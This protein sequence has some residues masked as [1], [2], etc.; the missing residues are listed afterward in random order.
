MDVDV[1]SIRKKVIRTKISTFNT[2]SFECLQPNLNAHQTEDDIPEWSEHDGVCVEWVAERYK[3]WRWRSKWSQGLPISQIQQWDINMIQVPLWGRWCPHSPHV[4][5]SLILIPCALYL[6]L[7]DYFLT[8]S[9][10]CLL[11]ISKWTLLSIT[12]CDNY[13]MCCGD[14][15]DTEQSIYLLSTCPAGWSSSYPK[16]TMA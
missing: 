14:A 10:N 13:I 15:I 6:T 11:H 9:K 12:L 16:K 4:I 7:G 3:I 5:S 8:L 2:S 1:V